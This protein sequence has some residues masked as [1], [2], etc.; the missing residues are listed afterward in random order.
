M[1]HTHTIKLLIVC[2]GRRE[3]LT[4]VAILL[5]ER[6]L[7]SIPTDI[8]AAWRVV[9]SGQPLPAEKEHLRAAILQWD[10]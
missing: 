8:I 2:G 6:G 1:R 7:A 4:L 10:E 3:A 9:F 5:A